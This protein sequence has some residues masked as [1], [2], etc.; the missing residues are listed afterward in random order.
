MHHHLPCSHYPGVF[1]PIGGEG[2]IQTLERFYT[3]H[4]FQSCAL[5]QTRRLL[6]LQLCRLAA[7]A[8]PHGSGA[9]SSTQKSIARSCL[10]VKRFFQKIRKL[11]IATVFCPW[12]RHVC[13][14]RR[15]PPPPCRRMPQA[16]KR[17]LSQLGGQL[18]PPHA[19]APFFRPDPP[20]FDKKMS[21]ALTKTML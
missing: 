21:V 10:F 1:P 4:D 3:L 16:G 17:F 20:F 7:V 19:I 14:R 13:A 11:P 5:D 8:P 12:R 15:P 2:E 9:G 6:H 18:L